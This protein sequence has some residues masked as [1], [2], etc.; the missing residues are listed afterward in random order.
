MDAS[1]R[2]PDHLPNHRPD[3]QPPDPAGLPRQRRGITPQ[4]HG[5]YPDH[6]VLAHA[7]H[8]DPAT[9]GVV[10]ARV[11]EVPP[12]RFFSR[13]QFACLCAFCDVVLAQDA[14]PRIPVMSFVDAKLHDGRLDG[15]QHVTMPDDRETWRLVAQGLDEVAQARGAERFALAEEPVQRRVVAAFAEGE[16]AGGVWDRLP[17]KTAWTVVMRAV[18]AAFYSHPWAWNE[19]GFGGPAYPRGYMRLSAADPGEARETFALD[20]VRDVDHRDM[21]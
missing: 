6:D 14:E 1:F 3:H 4:R 16:L 19:I 18:L 11:E 13:E 9:R 5:R 2:L 10:R 7:G 20:P 17:A 15:F 21:P 12:R 8:W